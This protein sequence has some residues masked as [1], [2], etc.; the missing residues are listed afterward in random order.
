MEI[1]TNGTKEKHSRPLWDKTEESS[2]PFLSGE[3]YGQLQVS[4]ME[5]HGV[6]GESGPAGLM[7]LL[8]YIHFHRSH[9]YRVL[10]GWWFYF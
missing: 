5:S 3:H 6:E 1:V 4:K 10:K 8:E 9:F 2:L 7:D